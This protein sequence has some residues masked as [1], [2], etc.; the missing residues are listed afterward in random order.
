MYIT[1][2]EA[3][4]KYKGSWVVF[5]NPEY[6]DKFHMNLIGGEFIGSADTEEDIRKLVP[7]IT[8]D[9][10]TDFYTCRHTEEDEAVGLLTSRF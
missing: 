5:K 4:V 2:E 7:A 3:K 8:D 9:N 6:T 10:D 1:W